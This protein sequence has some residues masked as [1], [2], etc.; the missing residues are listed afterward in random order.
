MA[1]VP[2]VS[3][4]TAANDPQLKDLYDDAAGRRGSVLNLYKA[5][6]NQPGALRAHLAMSRYVRDDS[7]L[8]PDLRELAILV[9]GFALDSEYEQ[10]HHLA[11]ARRAGVDEAKLAAF[12]DWRLSPHF[13]PEEIDVLEFADEIARN[14]TVS[15]RYYQAIVD[16][17]GTA[18]AID[19][20]VTCGFYHYCAVVLGTLGVEMEE[21][22]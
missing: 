18:G 6:A 16:R 14:R 20:T 12:P 13:S 22:E 2:Y 19:L 15:D 11:A 10:E 5:I 7:S 17:F 21:R 4:D 8:P 1:R 9:T 3:E